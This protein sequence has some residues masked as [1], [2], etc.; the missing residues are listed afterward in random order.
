MGL[1]SY[2][3]STGTVAATTYHNN[4]GITG[5]NELGA[6]LYRCYTAG[7][8]SSTSGGMLGGLTGWNFGT[9]SECYSVASVHTV[10]GYGT[11]GLAGG[12]LGTISDSYARGPVSGPGYVGGITGDNRGTVTRCYT[13]STITASSAYGYLVYSN[14]AQ[15]ITDSY[16]STNGDEYFLATLGNLLPGAW[17]TSPAWGRDGGYP[18]LVYFG[19]GTLL[20]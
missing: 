7:D 12:N 18:Y 13:T 6:T 19:A 5:V 10:S 11:G 1:I 14:Q 8:V 2:S 3:S 16:S 20:P 4:G 9:I 17:A 15:T